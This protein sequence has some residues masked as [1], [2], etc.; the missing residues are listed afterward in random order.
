M[1]CFGM[2]N[3]LWRCMLCRVLAAVSCNV[4]TLGAVMLGLCRARPVLLQYTPHQCRMYVGYLL[5]NTL[6]C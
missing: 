4:M 5:S 3:W 6:P 1:V 2:V